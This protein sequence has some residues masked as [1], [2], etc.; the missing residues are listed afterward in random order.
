MA[1]TALLGL[2]TGLFLSGCTHHVI[3]DE[4]DV[5]QIGLDEVGKFGEPLSVRLV[6][7]Q[8]NSE[9]YEF[10]ISETGS[11]FVN[12]NEWTEFF[13]RQYAK[14]LGKRGVT[15]SGK[16]PNELKVRLDHFQVM[17][18]GNPY[19]GRQKVEVHLASGSWTKD[20]A[21]L[22]K[23]GFGGDFN[24]VI[25]TSI[26]RLLKDPEVGARMKK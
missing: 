17:V 16:S 23:T 12:M 4:N 24:P 14:E 21:V 19:G 6:N 9:P 15:V 25:R 3:P 8:P 18:I 2:L 5:E 10:H 11:W 7:D 1:R 22:D 20:Y 26:M 13:I